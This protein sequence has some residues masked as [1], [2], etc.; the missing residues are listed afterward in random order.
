MATDDMGCGCEKPESDNEIEWDNSKG[1]A[2]PSLTAKPLM[3]SE[4]FVKSAG[5]AQDKD[6]TPERSIAEEVP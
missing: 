1:I 3:K 5:P 4:G 6:D 2:P